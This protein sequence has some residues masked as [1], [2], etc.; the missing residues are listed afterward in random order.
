MPLEGT[1]F[2][3]GIR[4]LVD[5]IINPLL[6]S[7][8]IIKI[9]AFQLYKENSLIL[10]SC[11]ACYPRIIQAVT[12]ILLGI[13]IVFIM[14]K[15]NIFSFIER[16]FEPPSLF[17]EKNYIDP[18]KLTFRFPEK[19]RNL[20]VIFIESL[21]TGFLNI[22]QG[23]AFSE[24][25]IGEVTLLAQNN[26]N[27]SHTN[28]IG[29][30]HQVY[31]TGWTIA[32][33]VSAYTGIPLTLP[34]GNDWNKLAFFLPSITGIGDILVKNGYSSYFILGSDSKFAGR[35]KYFKTHG[36]TVIWD[37]SYFHDEGYIDKDYRVWWGFEDRKL[38]D[39]AK[40]KLS[41]I[42]TNEAPFFFT[43][44]TADTHI[45]DGYLDD[46]AEKKYTSRY[47]NVLADMSR[48]L[49]DFINWIQ[50]QEFYKNTTIVILGDHLYMDTAVFQRE[51]K[52]MDRRPLNIF[53]NS[54]LKIDH[55][56]NRE[57]THFDL[58]PAI[59]DSIGI[60]YNANGIGLGRSMNK[61]EKTLIELSGKEQFEANL[62]KKSNYYEAFFIIGNTERRH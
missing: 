22:N 58:F 46:L 48:Q 52:N 59:L 49:F 28:F 3:I 23:G 4:F 53:I 35:D 32:G 6:A 38:Y 51:Q 45:A 29:G 47:K 10:K 9:C 13:S 19:K 54:E 44:L 62:M 43:L 12:G 50:Q 27:F 11:I 36:N 40:F 15:S 55:T 39:F 31:G 26:I 1:N 57:F 21:E 5:V 37:Y 24:D 18:G 20:I 61:G 60:E 14:S 30:G 7:I 56:K 17:Y 2:S 16:Q 42:S 25:L 34:F 33:I 8:V 41:V